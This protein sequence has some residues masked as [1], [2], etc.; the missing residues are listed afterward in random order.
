MTDTGWTKRKGLTVSSSQLHPTAERM[1]RFIIRY[2]VLN[3]GDSPSRREIQQA[4]RLASP[5]M[6]Q[7]HL[8]T[9]E[10]AGKICR[11]RRGAARMIAI[12]GGVWRLEP[13]AEAAD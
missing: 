1:Y 12:P 2:K 10:R 3:A 5:S 9:L 13:E 8:A 6:V 7:H 4:L 11:P